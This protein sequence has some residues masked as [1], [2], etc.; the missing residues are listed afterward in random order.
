MTDLEIILTVKENG[1]ETHDS[2]MAFFTDK[3]RLRTTTKEGIIIALE[4]WVKDFKK[5]EN[6]KDNTVTD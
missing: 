2:R 4:S 3:G 5:E 1:V 6:G